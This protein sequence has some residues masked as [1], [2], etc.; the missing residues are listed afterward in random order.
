VS[1]ALSLSADQEKKGKKVDLPTAKKSAAFY[2]LQGGS[3]ELRDLREKKRGE[4]EG[5]RER[6]RQRRILKRSGRTEAS[7]GKKKGG[8]GSRQPAREGERHVSR[9]KNFHMRHQGGGKNE[10]SPKKKKG[11]RILLLVRNWHK[12]PPKKGEGAI[13]EK[14]K[15]KKPLRKEGSNA[16]G[17][18]ARRQDEEGKKERTGA[19]FTRTEKKEKKTGSG[20]ARGRL[21]RDVI[22][23]GPRERKKG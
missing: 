13:N 5:K 22:A 21:P 18:L 1:R 14:K 9:A 7:N 2:A 15:E 4:G 20:S 10:P 23:D 11:K 16:P 8:E 6:S 12:V 17:P 19:P 3:S